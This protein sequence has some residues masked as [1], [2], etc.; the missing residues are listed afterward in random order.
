MTTP[1][2]L[3]ARAFCVVCALVA[4]G[5]TLNA[6]FDLSLT[7]FPDSHFTDYAKAVDG[8]KH[9]LLWLQAGLATLFVAL[10]VVPMGA[11]ARTLAALA[12]VVALALTAALQ[13][14]G[15]PWYYGTHLGLDNGIGG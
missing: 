13:W 3:I 10:A 5:L 2:N 9:V 8:P 6:A 4:A 12:A 11:R 14:V 15:V 7:G 1:T